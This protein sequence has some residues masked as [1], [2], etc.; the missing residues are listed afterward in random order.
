MDSWIIWS[1]VLKNAQKRLLPDIARFWGFSTGLYCFCRMNMYSLSADMQRS[2]WHVY[3]VQT[4]I[5]TASRV[6]DVTSALLIQ[7]RLIN[8]LTYLLTYLHTCSLSLDSFQWTINTAVAMATCL[9]HHVLQLS[10]IDA[11]SE[12]FKEQIGP[13]TGPFSHTHPLW[14]GGVTSDSHQPL[15][16]MSHT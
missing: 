3:S 8:L 9:S 1:G 6:H 2:D 16:Y 11:Q 5:F 12:L 13:P 10:S 4:D 14:V 15:L 7:H